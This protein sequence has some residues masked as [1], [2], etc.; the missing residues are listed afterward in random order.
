MLGYPGT[1]DFILQGLRASRS[2]ANT[3][4]VV[5]RPRDGGFMLGAWKRRF[6]MGGLQKMDFGLILG[7]SWGGLVHMLA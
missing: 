6:R 5:S 4:L 7:S 2:H 3:G 1:C